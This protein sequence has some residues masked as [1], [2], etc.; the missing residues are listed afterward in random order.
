MKTLFPSKS[1]KT[2]LWA[3]ILLAGIFIN[4]AAGSDYFRKDHDIAGKIIDFDTQ[5]PIPGVVVSAMWTTNVFRLT[6]EPDEKY[7]DYFE[8]RS[9]KNGEFKIP[10][11]GLNIIKNMP[12][13]K[14]RIFKTG[15]SSLYLKDLSPRFLQDSPLN[16]DVK[17][18]DGKYIIPFKERS[19]EERKSALREFVRVPFYKM[20]R[21]GVL[22]EKYRFYTEELEREYKALGMTP[23]WEQ[24]PLLLR[25][26]KGGV[27]PAK[28]KAAEPTKNN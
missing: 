7:Y 15:Y 22:P 18:M 8:T 25:S 14:I 4:T 5:K 19:L 2:F 9:D 28:E 17:K 26:K 1:L 16:G 23:A 27:Y 24:N 6:V 21:A 3:I 10:G 12:P 20:G 11:K 13:P